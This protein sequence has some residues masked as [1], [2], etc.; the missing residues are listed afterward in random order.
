MASQLVSIVTPAFNEAPN[1]Q[2]FYDQIVSLPLGPDF[3]FEL[4]FVNDGS[5][6]ETEMLIESVVSKDSRVRLVSLSRNFGHQAALSA[7]LDF[8]SGDVVITMD[9]DLQHPPSEVL[10]MLEEER[11]LSQLPMPITVQ[12][13]TIFQ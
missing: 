12:T 13:L 6:D 5:T 3:D 8:S 4:L 10:R 2:R 1:I 11:T 7:G 9:V